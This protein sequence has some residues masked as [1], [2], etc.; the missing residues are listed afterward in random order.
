MLQTSDDRKVL[1]L[2]AKKNFEDIELLGILLFGEKKVIDE[3]TKDF[4]LYS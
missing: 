4:S 3:L 2:T 1:E